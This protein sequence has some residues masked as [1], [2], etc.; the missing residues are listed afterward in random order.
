VLVTN[1][2]GAIGA[3]TVADSSPADWHEATAHGTQVFE[4]SA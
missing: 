3:G 2:D 4:V 1:A